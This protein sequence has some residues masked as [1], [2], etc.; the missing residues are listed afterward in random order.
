LWR[1][2]GKAPLRLLELMR[3]INDHVPLAEITV[4]P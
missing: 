1:R 4:T 3:Q 2:D